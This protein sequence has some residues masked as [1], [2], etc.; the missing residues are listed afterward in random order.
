MNN[1]LLFCVINV[2]ISMLITSLIYNVFLMAIGD[3]LLTEVCL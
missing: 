2:S 1:Q 3:P